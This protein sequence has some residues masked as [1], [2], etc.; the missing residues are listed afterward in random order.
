MSDDSTTNDDGL[1]RVT[2]DGPLA[3]LVPEP[4]TEIAIESLRTEGVYDDER[5][6]SPSEEGKIALPVTRPPTETQV[7]DVVRQVD[8][9]YRTTDLDSVLE[10]RGWTDAELENAPG[11]WAVVGDVVLVTIPPECP[12]EEAVA[13]ALLDLHGGA[14]TVLA[15]EGVDGVQR[16][17][18]TRHLAGDRDTETVH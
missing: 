18:Q 17:P 8:P 16:E 5:A 9:T 15:D 11:S 12:D 14:A 13:D 3:V 2:E 6:V 10:A 7:D 1:D 4:R